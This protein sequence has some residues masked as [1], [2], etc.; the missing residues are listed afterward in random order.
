MPLYFFAAY[1]VAVTHN[2]LELA[3]QQPKLS[4]PHGNLDLHLTHGSL[5]PTESTLQQ[6]S[7][8][9]QPFLRERDQQADTPTQ[10]DHATSYVAIGLSVCLFAA[11]RPQN[12]EF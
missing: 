7:W 5:G 2:V 11:M 3:G 9:V 10:T 6:A 1:T 4:L 12:N 8:S